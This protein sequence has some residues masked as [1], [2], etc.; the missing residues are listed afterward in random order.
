VFTG[1]VKPNIYD[2]EYESIADEIEVSL[3]DGLSTLQYYD[4]TV[5]DKLGTISFRQLLIKLLKKCNCY[6]QLYVSNFK[7]L[8]KELDDCD[9]LNHLFCYEQ[10]F[11]D[12]DSE[13][14][15]WK[16]D[17]I[18]THLLQYLDYTI[19]SKG[20]VVY[21]IS[22]NQMAVEGIDYTSYN[23]NEYDANG[24]FT[25]TN[26]EYIREGLESMGDVVS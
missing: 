1:Y 26:I 9:V 3:I 6:S 4:Y 21:V 18:L 22:Y 19:V 25:G 10:N 20:D 24:N 17:E 14:T 2:N 7:Q 5:N 16:C 23:L 15:A 12:N 13:K 11:F 8:E